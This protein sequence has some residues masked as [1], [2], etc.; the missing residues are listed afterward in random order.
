LTD[1][2]SMSTKAQ[3][4]QWRRIKE[5][6][7]RQKKSPSPRKIAQAITDIEKLAA[8]EADGANIT[9]HTGRPN[10]FNQALGQRI[11]D[12]IAAGLGLIE[13]ARQPDIKTHHEII[14][15]W[16][17][18]PDRHGLTSDEWVR[19]CGQYARARRAQAELD[20][21]RV[22]VIGR[23][24]IDGRIAPDVGRVAIQAFTWAAEKRAPR[25]FGVRMQRIEE[26]ARGQG[27]RG[28]L[29][30]NMGRA[31]LQKHIEHVAAQIAD[32]QTIIEGKAVEEIASAP[33]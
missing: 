26:I 18:D 28:Q 3:R 19:F 15:G 25:A 31:D 5:R 27:A 11:C 12:R 33:A 14:T 21:D 9:G 13:I 1:H 2:A 29:G 30:S 6:I 10:K 20:A 7:E 8:L 22:S 4:R 23:M 16:L 24:V 32:A 17:F